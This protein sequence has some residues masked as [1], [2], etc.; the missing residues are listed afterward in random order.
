MTLWCDLETFSET[1]IQAGTYRYAENCEVTIFA[2]AFDDGPVQV[3]DVTDGSAMPGDL[4]YAINDTDDLIYFHNSI[5]DRTVLRLSKNLHVTLPIERVRCTLVQALAHSLPGGLSALC[6]ILKVDEDKAKAKT[7]RALMMMFCKPR[8]VKS[9]I[10]RATR[11]THPLEWQGFLEYAGL[12]VVAMREVARKLPA[13]NFRGDEISLWHLDQQINDRGFAVDRVLAAAAREAVDAEKIL[14]ARRTQAITREVVEST[15]QRD[16]LLGYILAEYGVLLPDMQ[17]ATLER[18]VEDEGLP[19]ELRELLR[20]RLA[21]TTSSTSKYQALLR[22]A[23]SDGRLRGTMQFCGASRTGRWAHRAFQPG[24]LPRPTIPVDEIDQGIEAIKLGV[25]H[26]VLDDVMATASSAIRGC[27]VAPPGKKLVVG[28]LAAIEG[29]VCAWLCGEHWKLRAYE[30]YDAGTG[31]DLYKLANARAFAI[32]PE[33][34]DKDGRQIGKV[35]EL[36]LQYG[37]GV[38][39]FLTGATT[40]RIDLDAMT[41]ACMPTLPDDV[42]KEARAFL[43]STLKQNRST[44]GLADDTFVACDSLKRMWRA[45]NPAISSMWGELEVAIKAAILQPG[46]T[47]NVRGR[48]IR[49]DGAWLRIQLPSGRYLCY[50]SPKLDEGRITY[51]GV[52]QYTRKWQELDTYGGKFLEQITQA[53]SRDVLA[54]SMPSVEDAGY[55]IT[56]TVHDELVTEAPDTDAYSADGLC[57]LMSATPTWAPGLPLA[58]SGFET[59]RYRK[60]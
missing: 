13:W 55:A 50:P 3:W 28:D 22:G 47:H 30:A 58:A 19:D 51:M 37:G 52:D 35:M 60:G 49:C 42:V 26:E 36:M 59:L 6:D 21:A 5:F 4:D 57:A 20:I 41:K 34:V 43:A 1:P 29:R 38:G 31:P 40:Y 15:T 56:L 24:N 48:L 39:A 25:A 18:R 14:L 2:Y 9:T 33:E 11:G 46:I 16:K 53:A 23:S 32:T 7:G 27:I 45:S 12:D 17:S 54:Y 44:F 10:R 8:P